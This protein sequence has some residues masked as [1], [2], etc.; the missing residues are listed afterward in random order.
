MGLDV[1]RMELVGRGKA[2]LFNAL[3]RHCGAHTRTLMRTA[4][5]ADLICSLCC[6]DLLR[7]GLWDAEQ[8]A[9]STL[10]QSVAAGL[11]AHPSD[12]ATD[13]GGADDE[14][15]PAS[16]EKQSPR[17]NKS[18]PD[19]LLEDFFASRALCRFVRAAE[20]SAAGNALCSA[21]WCSTF[22]GRC[23]NVVPGHG[24]KVLAAVHAACDPATRVEM[25]AELAGCVDDVGKWAQRFVHKVEQKEK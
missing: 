19:P 17:Q 1:C 3:T 7:R 14:G 22:K 9:V 2:S 13:Q 6:G 5:G 16:C 11:A 8:T 24:A 12:H 20:G 23:A 15:Q 18:A 4:Q 25:D 10:Q 21:L